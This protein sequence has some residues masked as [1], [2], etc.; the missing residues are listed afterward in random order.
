M[1]TVR[2]GISFDDKRDAE[3]LRWLDAH[4]NA[5]EL[6]REVLWSAYQRRVTLEIVYD[7]IQQL[8]QAVQEIAEGAVARLQ[9]AGTLG[10]VFEDRDIADTLDKLGL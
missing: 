3:L 6:V 9:S 7:A 10:E 8:T 2:R 1:T 4:Q 5:S